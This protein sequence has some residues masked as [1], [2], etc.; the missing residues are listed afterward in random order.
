MLGRERTASLV[1]FFLLVGVL[2]PTASVLWF[3]NETARRDAEEARARVLEAYRGQLPLIRGRI[4]SFWSERGARLA[5]RGRSGPAADF[6]RIVNT[7][8]ADS[9]VLLDDRGLRAYPSATASSGSDTG[10]ASSA[11]ARDARAAIRARVRAG[12]RERAVREIERQFSVGAGA[13]GVDD[14]GRLIAADEL[15]LALQ[16]L[17]RDDARF[18]RVR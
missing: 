7:G 12:D 1:L 5:E 10:D 14:D 16:L 3:L 8:L 18:A 4:D 17:K 13:R 15:L 6:A 9:V 2:V 11:A